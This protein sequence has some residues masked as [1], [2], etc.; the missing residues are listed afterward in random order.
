MKLVSKNGKEVAQKM[1]ENSGPPA[2]PKLG[3]PVKRGG[4]V[5]TERA[6]HEAW[7]NLILRKPTAAAVLHKLVANMGSKNAVVISQHTLAAMVGV[8][9]RT[10]RTAIADLVAGRWIQVVKL[11]KGRE[12]AYVVNSRVAWGESR[13]GLR[14]SVF[15]AAIVADWADQEDPLLG[16][17]DLRRIPVLYPGEQQLPAGDGEPP[18]SQTCLDGM[19]PDLPALSE[20]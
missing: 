17:G 18:P 19:E 13:E 6:A 11:G 8:T 15:D 2:K 14:L 10:I 16:S 12:C 9:D 1:T 20:E 5:Q 7:A 3:A 4:W